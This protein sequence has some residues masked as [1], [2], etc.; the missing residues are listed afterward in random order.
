[1]CTVTYLPLNET[2]FIL[3]SNRDE[4]KWRD[5][6]LPVKEYKIGNLKVYY[7]KDT[8]AGGTW[9]ACAENQWTLCLLNGA[10]TPHISSSNYRLSRGIMLLNFFDYNNFNDFI[11][12]YNFDEI[13]PF[14]LLLI[15]HNSAT[16]F[17]ELKWDGNKISYR[18]VD[19]T[20]PHIWS[21]VTLYTPEI[22]DLRKKWFQNWLVL[23]QHYDENDIIDFH[24]HAGNGDKANSLMMKRTNIFQTVSITCISFLGEQISIKYF[25]TVNN[26][27][28]IARIVNNV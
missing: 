22:I 6:A 13:E 12:K 24:L 18:I 21:S 14:T 2:Q 27:K 17:Y 9:I 10:N 8:H 20:I 7:P 15:H 16:T 25:D 4:K 3:T 19:H 28:N 11:T 23:N 5:C 26:K 1:M